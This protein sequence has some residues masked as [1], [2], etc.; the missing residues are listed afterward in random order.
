MAPSSSAP[1]RRVLTTVDGAPAADDTEARYRGRFSW[2][3]VTWATHC[4]NCIA[5]CSYRLYA[6]D[7]GVR[8]EEQSGVYPASAPGIPDPNPMGCQKGAAWHRQLTSED[9]LLH[10][11]RRVGPRGSGRWE[12]ISWDEALAAVADAVCDAVE[13]SGPPAGL[14]DETSEGGMLTIG[15]QSRFASCLG[16]VSLDA[17]ASVN[18]IPVGHHITFGNIMGGCAA[19][20]TFAADVVLIWHANP[21]YTRIPYF[22]YLTEARYRGARIIHIAPDVNASSMHA[23][24]MVPVR[25]GTDAA[26]GLAMCQ[27]MVA[28]GLV[29]EEFVRTQ[30]DLALLVRDDDGRL[31]RA[32][33]LE[34]G[35]GELVFHTWGADAGLTPTSED[36]LFG[37]EPALLRGSFEVCLADGSVVGV[38]PA[39]ELLVDR[40]ASF[41]PE[42]VREVC[43]VHPDVIRDV[44]RMVA[45]GR[46]KLHEGFD[47]S[48][49]YHGDLMERA[50]DL[51]LALSGNWGRPGTGHDTYLTYPF[52]G[53]YLQGL[54]PGPGV[55]NAEL[56]IEMM[57]GAFGAADTDGGVPPPLPRPAIW[58]FMGMAAAGG[59]TTPPFF[60]WYDHAGYREVLERSDWAPTPRPFAD[61]VAQAR[62]EWAP[63]WRPGP[64]TEPR[65]LIEGATNALRRTRGGARMLLGHLWPK[66]SMVAVI[67]QRMS[68]VAM[69]ADIVLPA[70][71]EAERV[72]LQ[73]PI[74]HS[75]E[76]VFSDKV[77]E[78]AGECRTDWQIM[79]DLSDAV[80][81]RAEARGLG[82]RMVG[83]GAPRALRELGDAYAAGGRLRDEELVIDELV[84]DSALAGAIPGGTTIETLRRDGWAPVTGNGCL[85][86][87]RW[88]G[89][90]ITADE[91]FVALRW[92]V[93]DGMPYATT[94]GRA[95][96]YVDHPWFLEADEALPTHKEPPAIGGDHPFVL[97]GGHPRW[98]IHA[99][100]ATNPLLLAT[101]RGEP[102]VVL[103]PGD[104]EA[105]GIADHDRVEVRND[106]GSLAVHARLSPGVRPGQVILYASWDPTGFA[107]WGDGTEIE[108]GVVKWLLLAHGWGHLRAMPMHWQPVHVD[109]VHRVDVV[110]LGGDPAGSEPTG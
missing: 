60:L 58:D 100:N 90:P 9:R 79:A 53:S 22:H 104:A 31:L 20:D 36:T 86:I 82:D 21:A 107:R 16:A 95:T 18:D 97:T 68:S 70:A 8:F 6:T 84:R 57:R 37:V 48:K 76:V 26:L 75:L 47:T 98:S 64:D 87:G 66:L 69:H 42:A 46:T 23:D 30:T 52:D 10:P 19:E 88:L 56:V 7:G 80:A 108:A 2:E 105:G 5:T 3:R 35:G 91:P 71:Q 24:L 67:D 61:Y 34:A 65:V 110:R 28:E 59:S 78:P 43:G 101:T 83:W 4:S 33:D 102:T 13:A 29:D 74:S 32:C 14:V 72:N 55:E 40:L 93:E 85:P 38:R 92:H 81:A 63:V 89:G 103:N 109:R 54:K 17:I 99:C 12:Q 27:V 51:V 77:L 106:L 45:G 44:A 41:T 1:P 94:T 73:Y 15:A 49:H 25:P 39:Y 96:F 62:T 11:L 50:M